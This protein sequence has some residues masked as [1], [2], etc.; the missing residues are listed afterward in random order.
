M[1][2]TPPAGLTVADVAR[3][4]RV[5]PDK[6]RGWIDRRELAALNT[7]SSLS[8]RPRYVVTAEALL[9]FERARQ[10]GPPPALPRRARRP[11]GRID[12]YPD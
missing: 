7:A 8:G 4:Y 10:A 1:T 9:E 11:A 2:A 12:F 5:G 6:V 3:R